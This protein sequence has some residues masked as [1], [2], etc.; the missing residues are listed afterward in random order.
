MISTL[1]RL[2]PALSTALL[3]GML[4]V[5]SVVWIDKSRLYHV[6]QLPPP[7]VSLTAAEVAAAT[8]TPAYRGG[9]PVLTYHGISDSNP[10]EHTVSTELFAK[11]LA[12]LRQAGFTSITLGMLN[13]F[14]AGRPMVL[15]TKPVVITFDGGEVNAWSRA[16]PILQAYGFRAVGFLITGS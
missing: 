5:A 8:S 7:P 9:I 3:I 11:H 16:D 13:D 14:I 12:A 6:P 1:R 4:V 15:P 2:S 10:S